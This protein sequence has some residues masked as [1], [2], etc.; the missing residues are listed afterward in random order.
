MWRIQSTFTKRRKYLNAIT[1][2]FVGQSFASISYFDCVSDEHGKTF[3]ELN[4]NTDHHEI[5]LGVD[6]VFENGAVL[7]FYWDT[8]RH[9]GEYELHLTEKSCSEILNK[10]G[11]WKRITMHEHPRFQTFIGETITNFTFSRSLL[12]HPRD[13]CV[14]DC[15][16]DFAHDKSFW[17]CNRLHHTIQQSGDDL[18]VVFDLDFASKIGIRVDA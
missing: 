12:A 4:N 9:P 10:D 13:T 5:M 2:R 7:G 6:L 14:C 17:I 18:I 3:F 15:R 11:A 8:Y 1:D 16:I